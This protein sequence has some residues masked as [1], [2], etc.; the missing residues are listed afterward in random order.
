MDGPK[1]EDMQFIASVRTIRENF[2]AFARMFAKGERKAKNLGPLRRYMFERA[3]VKRIEGLHNE[4][5]RAVV[6]EIV[7][8]ACT[9]KPKVDPCRLLVDVAYPS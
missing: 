5:M 3:E 8:S 6:H 4:F 1:P 7:E 9:K 2:S